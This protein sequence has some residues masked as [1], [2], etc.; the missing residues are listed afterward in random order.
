MFSFL[1]R[2]T[3]SYSVFFNWPSNYS[4]WAVSEF[5]W[6]LNWFLLSNNV[7]FKLAISFSI[8]FLTWAVM[9]NWFYRSTEVWLIICVSAN[10]LCRAFMVSEP[11][12]MLV[13]G[14]FWFIVL[15]DYKSLLIN[16]ATFFK[17]LISC[18]VSFVLEAS[19]MDVAL[20]Y[21]AEVRQPWMSICKHFTNSYS[22]LIIYSEVINYDSNNSRYHI[23][24]F[25]APL[26]KYWS[27][28]W[29][30]ESFTMLDSFLLS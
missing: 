10:G 22:L 13:F 18:K 11:A 4:F 9:F 12:A 16:S 8:E 28:A 14:W 27:M 19:S 30:L 25:L 29:S 6:S 23:F 21:A 15:L 1:N 7:F 26:G 2:G 24:W 17:S 5:N 3:N 20:I